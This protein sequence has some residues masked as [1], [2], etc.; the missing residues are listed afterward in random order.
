MDCDNLLYV[1]FY[2][3]VKEFPEDCFKNCPKLIRTGGTALAFASLERIGDGAYE[4]CKSLTSSS[5]WYL[6][7]YSNLKEI[8]NHAFR[9]CTSLTASVLSSTIN[10]I[11]SHA[12][13]ECTKMSSLTFNGT[14]PPEIGTFS[15]ETMMKGFLFKVPDSQ[16]SDDAVYKAYFEKLKEA[17][18]SE[19]NVYPILDSVSDGAKDRNTPAKAEEAEDT[20]KEDKS[21]NNNEEINNDH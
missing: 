2:G 11:G 4:G 8:G 18:S 19:E 20:T 13:D 14:T 12:F 21:E 3:A 10:K 7:R 6:G 5:S 1:S 16:S 17:L 15:P 9:G